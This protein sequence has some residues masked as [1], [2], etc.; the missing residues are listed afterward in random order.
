MLETFENIGP[1]WQK[2]GF[3]DV[4]RVL[5]SSIGLLRQSQS[6]NLQLEQEVQAVVAR[7]IKDLMEEDF[8]RAKECVKKTQE[9]RN[10]YHEVLTNME[11]EK[12]K[13]KVTALDAENQIKRAAAEYEVSE[14]ECK[15]AVK[16]AT[17]KAQ[18]AMITLT[19]NYLVKYQ[20]FWEKGWKMNELLTATANKHKGVATLRTERMKAEDSKVHTVFGVALEEVVRRDGKV[21]QFVFDLINHICS[22]GLEE[23]GLFRVPGNMEA[24]NNAKKKIDSGILDSMLSD[25]NIHDACGL[26]KM[27]FRELPTPLIPYGVFDE[28]M[29]LDV[30]NIPARGTRVEDAKKRAE[31]L[32][33]LSKL[34]Q[35]VQ[36]T[37]KELVYMCTLI[38]SKSEVNKMDPSNIA[39]SLAPGL[40]RPEV[41]DMDTILASSHKTNELFQHWIQCYPVYF[42]R[43][44]HATA[45]SGDVES[46]KSLM[47]I[48]DGVAALGRDDQ[49]KTILHCAAEKGRFS[50]CQYLLEGFPEL[51][52]VDAVDQNKDTALHLA[53]RNEH[54]DVAAYLMV[55]KANP[56]LMNKS[57]TSVW[58]AA[59]EVSSDFAKALREKSDAWKKDPSLIIAVESTL[60]S[61]TAAERGSANTTQSSSQGASKMPLSPRQ[62]AT[63]VSGSQSPPPP[64]PA[65]KPEKVTVTKEEVVVEVVKDEK[66]DTDSEDPFAEKPVEVSVA[67]KNRTSMGRRSEMKVVVQKEVVHTET[68]V[69]GPPPVPKRKPEG[70][71]DGLP[72]IKAPVMTKRGSMSAKETLMSPPKGDS[73]SNTSMVSP[74]REEATPTKKS[75]DLGKGSAEKSTKRSTTL[76]VRMSEQ[77]ANAIIWKNCRPESFYEITPLTNAVL[78]F[79]AL[80]CDQKRIQ[81]MNAVRQS[82]KEIA[83]G[84]QS[85]FKNMDLMLSRFPEEDSKCVKAVATKLKQTATELLGVVKEISL[86]QNNSAEMKKG[87]TKLEMQSYN[88][89]VV[90]MELFDT[91]ELGKYRLLHSQMQKTGESAALLAKSSNAGD[92]KI[93]REFLR[94]ISP[95]LGSGVVVK[96]LKLNDEDH[97]NQIL[98]LASSLLKS[99]RDIRHPDLDTMERGKLAKSII[100]NF[101]SVKSCFK[102]ADESCLAITR[103]DVE[104]FEAL[105][106]LLMEI[107]APDDYEPTNSA[108]R[109][110]LGAISA[111]HDVLV[112]KKEFFG[113][114]RFFGNH[115]EEILSKLSD[116]SRVVCALRGNIKN[117]ES[118]AK[119][120]F[121]IDALDYHQA[122]VTLIVAHASIRDHNIQ[123]ERDPALKKIEYPTLAG[124]CRPAVA[125]SGV[126]SLLL[127]LVPVVFNACK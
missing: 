58:A 13:G 82:L 30:K 8:L 93:A 14:L 6:L 18:T 47:K 31:M 104:I 88:L 51:V 45:A 98:Q 59:N 90:T 11:R 39:R 52:L 76:H 100:L 115:F 111:F 74:G 53:V 73:S 66:E 10:T 46:M 29:K 125:F 63:A 78:T 92:A 40:M 101:R 56:E 17:E 85:F 121:F 81:D 7:P 102:E 44:L 83:R 65:T 114:W 41:E 25:I 3:E 112:A 119:V 75:T 21:P 86:D 49:G 38:A 118:L 110:L 123:P 122:R 124:N 64:R 37:L 107:R 50:M 69:T 108:E 70:T 113:T 126:V 116:L 68:V 36:T 103:S 5:R 35:Y 79:S 33:I 34:P 120:S 54:L 91:I 117:P 61:T 32:T 43:S 94:E 28:L 72:A 48:Q 97:I 12:K 62:T 55:K 96:G 16:V 60:T 22:S 95:D 87:T 57:G 19:C 4:H 89:A 105:C 109:D 99:L 23:E 127:L 84:L 77:D 2:E 26:L 20:A 15:K 80:V 1:K 42:E 106:D 67:T 27:Y 9:N 71:S 24:L